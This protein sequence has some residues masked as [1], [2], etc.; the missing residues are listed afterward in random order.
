MAGL[1]QALG[2]PGGGGIAP[3]DSVAEKK[4]HINR[5]IG[6]SIDIEANS[7]AVVSRPVATKP[8]V[9]QTSGA[10]MLEEHY[11]AVRVK[12]SFLAGGPKGFEDGGG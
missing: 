8:H 2:T 12:Q 10:F 3:A 7:G 5:G 11:L 1:S 6:F 9:R 4:L